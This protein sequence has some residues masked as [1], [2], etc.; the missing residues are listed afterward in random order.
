VQIVVE[1][2]E[3]DLRRIVRDEI[4]SAGLADEWLTP[5]QASQ[6]IGLAVGTLRNAVSDGRLPRH[7]SKGHALRLKR[8]DLDHFMEGRR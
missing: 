7:G 4:A 2:P 5:A 3:D 8:G 6:Y 1:V